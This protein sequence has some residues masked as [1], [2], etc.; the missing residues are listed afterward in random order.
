MDRAKFFVSPEKVRRAYVFWDAQKIS[1]Q[2]FNQLYMIKFST[3]DKD[4]AAT[5]IT[6]Y[7]NHRKFCFSRIS[8]PIT[9]DHVNLVV[10]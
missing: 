6:A 2:N 8:S 9:E 4:I 1:T 10:I 7:T 5:N 3:C